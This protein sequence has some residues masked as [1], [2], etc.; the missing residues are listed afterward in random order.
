MERGG[1]GTVLG[2]KKSRSTRIGARPLRTRFF[3]AGPDGLQIRSGAGSSRAHNTTV[4]CAKWCHRPADSSLLAMTAADSAIKGR[5]SAAG[6]SGRPE[7]WRGLRHRN[8]LSVV[9]QREAASGRAE[10][11]A[12][13]ACTQIRRPGSLRE[14]ERS[15]K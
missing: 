12:N 5:W 9:P 15:T 4:C 7:T 1:R 2:R 14:N 8:R 3:S 11:R 13:E 6:R 10:I